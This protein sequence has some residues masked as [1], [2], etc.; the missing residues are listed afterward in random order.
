[1]SDLEGFG[2]CYNGGIRRRLQEFFILVQRPTHPQLNVVQVIRSLAGQSWECSM[3]HTWREANTCADFLAREA[4]Y[5]LTES[6]RELIE[7]RLS[8]SRHPW[9]SNQKN[10]GGNPFPRPTNRF[11]SLWLKALKL[12]RFI[13]PITSLHSHFLSLSGKLTWQVLR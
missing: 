1:M 9:P 2:N 11:P 8:Q 13:S 4:M 12:F 3:T 10:I 6:E 7:V 5:Q